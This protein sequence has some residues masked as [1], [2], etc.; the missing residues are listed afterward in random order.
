MPVSRRDVLFIVLCVLGVVCPTG[1]AD[2]PNFRGPNHDGI[3]HEKGLRTV[4]SRP[5]PLVWERSLG[6]AYSSFACVGDKIYTCGTKNKQQVLFCLDAGTGRTVWQTVIE[7]EFPESNGDGTR[8]TPTVDDGRVYVLG[9]HGR[10]LCANT[11]NGNEIWSREFHHKPTRG[12]SGSVLIDG[13]LAIVSAGMSDGALVAF[14]KKTG[15]PVW[16]TGND[17]DGYATPYPFT[18]QGRRYLV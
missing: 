4:G 12:Y 18:Y 11:T 3:S 5:M 17:G 14:D 2:W 9:A 10:L 15:E 13:G 8:A 6:S 16:K 1:R 7:N